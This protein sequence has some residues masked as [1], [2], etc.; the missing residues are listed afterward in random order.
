MR[1]LTNRVCVCVMATGKLLRQRTSAERRCSGK[2]DRIHD[3][4]EKGGSR[5]SGRQ[6]KQPSYW[7]VYVCMAKMGRPK[8]IDN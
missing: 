3:R 2:A 1:F 8:I 5:S 7:C 4:H 6:G